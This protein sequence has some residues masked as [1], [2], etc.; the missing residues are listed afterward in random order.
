META[1]NSQEKRWATGATVTVHAGRQDSMCSDEENPEERKWPGMLGYGPTS[2]PRWRQGKQTWE[3]R[4][5]CWLP[6]KTVFQLCLQ[7]ELETGAFPP[8]AGFCEPAKA[9][10]VQCLQLLCIQWF[11]GK[12]AH[13]TGCQAKATQPR[14]FETHSH[15][16]SCFETLQNHA[17][18]ETVTPGPSV[19]RTELARFTTTSSTASC[20]SKLPKKP[21]FEW[22]LHLVRNLGFIGVDLSATSTG[23]K[24]A[25]AIFRWQSD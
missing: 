1:E 15:G 16:R 5:R 14:A 22:I 3:A 17:I 21:G 13:S 2:R 8:R 18:S 23:D 24:K 7:G 11:V 9:L 20:S 6:K 25:L 19:T 10:A 12:L 4:K